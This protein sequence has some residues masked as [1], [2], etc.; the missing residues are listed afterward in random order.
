[1]LLPGTSEWDALPDSHHSHP[2]SC[3]LYS[4]TGLVLQTEKW[5]IGLSQMDIFSGTPQLGVGE[6]SASARKRILSRTLFRSAS[7]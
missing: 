4:M 1:M 2:A 7:T 6:R 3:R 5:V